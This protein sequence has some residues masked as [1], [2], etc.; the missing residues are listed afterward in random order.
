MYGLQIRAS[1]EGYHPMRRSSLRHACAGLALGLGLALS[2]QSALAGPVAIISGQ[3]SAPVSD[4]PSLFFH[5]T[6]AFDFTNVRVSAQAYNGSNALLPVG[7]D[8]SAYNV[9]NPGPFHRTQI[10]TLPNILAGSTFTFSF[11]DGPFACGSSVNKGNLFASDYDDTYGCST[12][13]RPGNVAFTFTADWNG[14]SIFA[15]FSPDSNATGGFLGFL[16]LDQTGNAESSFDNGGASAG[17]GQNGTLAQISVGTPPSVPEPASI[18]LLGIALLG[19]G[20][21]QR[22]NG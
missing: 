10:K 20:A 3:Y 11:L 17:T 19:L 13:A 1:N 5:N 18:A 22:R 12:A 9:L 16:G 6:T 21:I 14:Q 4:T 2:A 7:T 15:V 8:I